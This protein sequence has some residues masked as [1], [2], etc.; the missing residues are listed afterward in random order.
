[1][2]RGDLENDGERIVLLAADDTTIRDFEYNDKHPWP[3]SADGDGYSLVLIAPWTDPDHSDPLNWRSSVML[4]GIPADSDAVPFAG[5]PA[6]D[7]DEDRL[8]A[9]LE[10]ALGTSDAV[11]FDGE[12]YTISLVEGVPSLTLQT[13][14]AADDVLLELEA[15]LDLLTWEPADGFFDLASRTNNGDGSA[16]LVFEPAGPTVERLFVRVR[17][18]VR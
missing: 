2:F 6:A 1:M 4:H 10:H 3:E 7:L 18:T 11:P 13:N 15:S 8:S 5:D 17:A 16:T 14:L 9:L 12:A